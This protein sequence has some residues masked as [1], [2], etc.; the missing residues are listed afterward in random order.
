[1]NGRRT[2]GDVFVLS[3]SSARG[4]ISFCAKSQTTLRNCGR[5]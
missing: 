2:M 1:M 3:I 4:A 5:V